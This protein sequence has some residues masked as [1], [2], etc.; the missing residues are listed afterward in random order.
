MSGFAA[1][2]GLWTYHRPFIADG[3]PCHVTLRSGLRGMESILFVC[4]VEHDRCFRPAIGA[5]AALNHHLTAKLPSGRALAV[6]AGYYSWLNVA[7]AARLDGALI[8]ESHPGTPI[9]LPER[10]AKMVSQ[11]TADGTPVMDIGKL[12]ANRVPIAVDIATGL[13]FFIV[14]KLTDLT[15]AALVGAAVGIALV[16][17]QHFIKTD[18]L[19]GL[20]M[21]GIVMM[22][23]SSGL[24]WQFQDD[25]WVK[26]RSTI[27][28]LIGATAFL[29]DGL[30]L[31][32]RFIGAGLSRYIAYSDI[33]PQRLAIGMGIVGMMMAVINFAVARLTSTDVWL[34]YT[35][36]GDIFVS[37]AMVIY[38]MGW[39]RRGP[40]G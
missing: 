14:A 6:E 11:T 40:A 8:H 15:T 5:S 36:F 29:T 33:R 9:K 32:G 31:K 22:L 4:D 19:G 16:I 25:D 2:F 1:G 30:L 10:A 38:A 3:L 37:M 20:V 35:T 12:K 13:L 39:A 27:V 26:Q 28:G 23:I 17:I 24:A 18:I 34:F 21:F 7:I